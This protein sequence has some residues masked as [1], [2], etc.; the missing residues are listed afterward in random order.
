MIFI[1][2][3]SNVITPIFGNTLRQGEINANE[4][5]LLAPY[6]PRY[7]TVSLRVQLPNGIIIPSEPQMFILNPI[8][9]AEVGGLNLK[10]G[11]VALN[12]WR[13]RVDAAITQYAGAV[14]FQ[15]AI[16]VSGA[17]D[18][19]LPA[20]YTTTTVIENVPRGVP[21]IPSGTSYD[22]SLI[23][24]Y[25]AAIQ[26]LA[27]A[28]DVRADSVPLM[29]ILDQ[30]MFMKF[31]GTY[32]G[33]TY[34]NPDYYFSPTN[35]EVLLRCNRAYVQAYDG[36]N[37]LRLGEDGKGLYCLMA[38]LRYGGITFTSSEGI[39]VDVQVPRYPWMRKDEWVETYRTRNPDSELSDEE[40]MTNYP[41]VWTD[42]PFMS[43]ICERR[44]DG[45]I[46][47]P[48]TFAGLSEA[49]SRQL[50]APKDYVDQMAAE[51]VR[52]ANEYTNQTAAPKLKPN[53]GNTYAYCYNGAGV[54]LPIIIGAN[55]ALPNSI[56]QRNGNGV[57]VTATSGGADDA[58]NVSWANSHFVANLVGENA[59][60][61]YVYTSYNGAPK[62]FLLT[63]NPSATAGD[64]VPFRRTNGRL[65][66]GSPEEAT[67]A[68]NLQYFNSH[69]PS[70][71]GKVYQHYVSV[72]IET[73]YYNFILGYVYYSSSPTVRN[74]SLADLIN[75]NS[76][77]QNTLTPNSYMI[78]TYDGSY[79]QLMYISFSQTEL[80]YGVMDDSALLEDMVDYSSITSINVGETVTEV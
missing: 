59:S 32:N 50:A 18:G 55:T 35:W 24:V 36:D 53:S 4:I 48:R 49:E 3:A 33:V 22:P 76:I 37:D 80:Y 19:T 8:E 68:V 73:G 69:L 34:D 25:N 5:L 70:G 17:A 42:Y 1:C 13:M 46:R 61:R 14:S 31:G 38:L 15:W 67:D 71:G 62:L 56:V 10:L 45:R 12:A 20:V 9:E 52:D 78:D 16:A 51:A 27:E 58:V 28:E 77:I 44:P 79:V 41:P 40:I 65:G 43:T 39:A 60:N 57:V 75:N 72:Y 74:N 66:V 21:S 6:T 54:E 63:K 7:T 29:T 11:T 23:D 47:I 64:T 2:N 30:M 26:A